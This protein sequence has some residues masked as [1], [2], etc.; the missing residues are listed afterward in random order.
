[1]STTLTRALSAF[2]SEAIETGGGCKAITIDCAD[3][4]CILLTSC[5]DESCWPTDAEAAVD[6]GRYD[7]ESYQVEFIAAVPIADLP[8]LLGRLTAA[9]S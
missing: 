4:G 6:V 8:D 2:R 5:E 1:M 3:G 9:R 7:A